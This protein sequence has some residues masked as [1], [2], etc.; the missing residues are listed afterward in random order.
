[1]Q[2]S[3]FGLRLLLLFFPGVVCA[4]VVDALTIHRRRSEFEFVLNS[5]MLGIASYLVCW[6]AL[7]AWHRL[8]GSF[9]ELVFLRALTDTKVAISIRELGAATVVA[10]LLALDLTGASTYKVPYR[11]AQSLGI[12]KKFGELDLWG[13]VFN[14]K[15]VTWA[16]V[17]DHGRNLTYD[18]WVELFS[19]DSQ[20][21]ELLLSDVKVYRNDSGDF[22]Y[23][24]DS[25]YLSLHRDAIAIEFRKP[26]DER[27]APDSEHS[28]TA[29]NTR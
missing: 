23:D 11:L 5:L 28:E 6:L 20:S 8:D 12:T 7:D 24:A 25:M 13:Y 27:I 2:L 26:T 19:D 18:G 21:A 4:Y 17:R 22:L 1:M 9:H 14:S 16:T 10:V 15:N 29:T 3:E